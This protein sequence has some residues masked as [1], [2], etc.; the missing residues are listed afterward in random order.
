MHTH[1]MADGSG[2]GAT[3]AKLQSDHQQ[4]QHTTLRFLQA[5]CPSC[6][7]TNSDKTLKATLFMQ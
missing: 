6:H 3:H 1:I 2:A 4:Q 7:I 5:G